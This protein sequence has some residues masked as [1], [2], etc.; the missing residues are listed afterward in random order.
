MV[1]LKTKRCLTS[2]K[3]QKL[4]IY[5]A[6]PHQWHIIRVASSKK[7]FSLIYVLAKIFRVYRINSP[8]MIPFE[9]QGGLIDNESPSSNFDLDKKHF[10]ST[11][12]EEGLLPLW[13]SLL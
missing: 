1:G 6:I 10:G 3:S 5:L 4:R 12:M 9:P 11:R 7:S 13:F 8:P 2:T